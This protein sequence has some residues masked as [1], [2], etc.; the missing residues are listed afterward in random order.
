[1]LKIGWA[2]KD[3]TPE[4]P[5]LLDGQFQA[6]IST[7]VN[8]PLTVTALAIEGGNGPTDQAIMISCD[9]A[10]TRGRGK[11]WGVPTLTRGG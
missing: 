2:T 9:L 11:G 7:H 6:R 1:M 8:D 5:V 10:A 4:R 3:M